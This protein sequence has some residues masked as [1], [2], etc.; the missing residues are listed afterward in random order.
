[1]YVYVCVY[2]CNY[3]TMYVYTTHYAHIYKGLQFI[4]PHNSIYINTGFAK[5]I[6]LGI[7]PQNNHLHFVKIFIFWIAQ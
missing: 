1:M 3:V 7:S 5:N 4:L 2:V 6:F